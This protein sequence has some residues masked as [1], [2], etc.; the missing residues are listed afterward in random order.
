MTTPTDIDR[1]A[2]IVARHEIYIAAP[3]E[4]VWDLHINVDDWPTWNLEVSAA[5]LDGAFAPGNSFTWTSYDFTVTSTIYVVEDRARTLWGGAAQGIMGTHEWLFERTPEGVHVMT[6]E[7]FA[8]DPVEADTAGMQ[9]ILDN[10]LTTWLARM[11]ARAESS[12]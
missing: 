1:N 7:S 11:K 12:A 5:K 3:L 10:S 4:K 8:G 2:P 6:N 9:A